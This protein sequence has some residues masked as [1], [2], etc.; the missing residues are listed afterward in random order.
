MSVEKTLIVKDKTFI[1]STTSTLVGEG[2]AFN[3]LKKT[4]AGGCIVVSPILI[5][6]RST[7]G[8]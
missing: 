1:V 8:G 4:T 3:L 7:L 2:L 5:C 6:L